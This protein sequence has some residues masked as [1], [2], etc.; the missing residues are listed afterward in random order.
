M[1]ISYGAS[2]TGVG[3]KGDVTKSN[4]SKIIIGLWNSLVL[5]L[6]AFLFARP[7]TSMAVSSAVVELLV[8]LLHHP[9]KGDAPH[10]T[11]SNPDE[12]ACL[13]AVPHQI[14]GALATFNQMLLGGQSF[15]KCTGCSK[16]VLI[17]DT[18]LRCCSV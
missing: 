6:C 17:A 8:A 15:D 9:L 1:C 16:K 3:W 11:E 2:A 7:G 5:Y 10:E 14:R 12:G 4:N 13:G 18:A